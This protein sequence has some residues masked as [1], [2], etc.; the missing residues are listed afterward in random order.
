M[1]TETMTKH[2]FDAEIKSK[3]EEYE[4]L[5]VKHANL[6]ISKRELEDRF[7]VSNT[8]LLNMIMNY[9]YLMNPK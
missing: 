8:I 5:S 1:T 3:D 9:A 4:S 2:K 7:E 6:L